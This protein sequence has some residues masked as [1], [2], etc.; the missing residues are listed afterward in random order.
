MKLKLTILSIFLFFSAQI[1]AE[2]DIYFSK[3]GMENGLSQPTVISIYQDELGSIWFATREGVNRYNGNNS[4]TAIKPI[5]NDTNSLSGSLVK[6]ICGN[7][8]EKIYIQTQN[9]VD[10]YDLETSKIS[11][12]ERKQINTIDYGNSNLWIA[13]NENLFYYQNGIKKLYVSLPKKNAEIKVIHQSK[14]GLIY[15]GTLSSG[16]Y[17]V[18]KDRSIRNILSST[19]Q[20]SDIFEDSKSN[21]WIATWENGLY[22]IDKNKQITQISKKSPNKLTLSTNFVRTICEDN[23][24]KIW[25][26]TDKGL[27][28]YTDSTTTLTHYGSHKFGNEQLSN[29]SIWALFKDKQGTIWVGTY[30]GGVNYFN[31]DANFYTYHNLQKG[32]LK[33][34]QFPIISTIIEAQ[35]NRLFLCTEGNGLILYNTKTKTYRNF[36]SQTNDLSKNNIKTAYYDSKNNELWLG[37]HLGGLNKLN[38][39]NF[40]FSRYNKIKPN[41]EQSDIV[42]TILPYKEKLLIAT[43]NGLFLFDKKTEKF[44]LFDKKLHKIVSYYNDI[45]IDKNNNLWIA[46]RGLYRYNILTGKWKK[47]SHKAE[48]P[49]SLSNKNVVKI[50]IDSKDRIWIASNGGGINLY[51]PKEDNFIHYNTT[52]S[53]LNNNY[54]SNIIESKSGHLLVTTTKG[55]SI[56]DTQQNKIHNYGAENGLALNSF[57]NGGMCVLKNGK[58]YLA[59]MNGMVS[60]FEDKIGI[61]NNDFKIRLVNLWINNTLVVPKDETDVLE[62]SLPYTK[63]IKLKHNQSSLTIEFASNNYISANQP[64]YRYKLEGLSNSWTTLPLGENKLNFINLPTGNYKLKLEAISQFNRSVIDS[65]ELEITKKPIFYRS[66]L[67]Y[68]LYI[69][70]IAFIIWRLMK[71]SRSQLL[72]KTSLEYE[73]K[74]KAHI[75]QVNQSKLKFFTNISHEFRT[76]L[77]LIGGQIDMILQMH[78]IPSNVYNK[79]LKIKRNTNNMKQLVDELL[80][81]RKSEQGFL[82]IQ[83]K[84]QDFYEFIQEIFH[85]FYDY[86][87]FKNIKFDLLCNCNKNKLLLWY[88]SIQMQ[89]VFYNLISNAFKYTNE[90]GSITI[91]VSENEENIEINITDTGIG[92]DSESMKNIFNRFY[93]VEHEAQSQNITPSTGIG[94]A[95]TKNILALHSATIKV[96]SE[97]GKGSIFTVTLKKGNKHFSEKQKVTT[98][99]SETPAVTQ[100]IMPDK[101]FIDEIIQ[102]YH[103][104]ENKNYSILIVEDN[105]EL[106][107]MQKRIFEPLYKVYTAKDGEE[108]LQKAIDLQPSI[109]LSDLMMPKMSGSE[110]CEKI[111]SNFAVCHIPVV[112]LTAQTAMEYNL[113]GL[114]LGA[115][116]YITKPFNV[117]ILIMRCNN[118]V[119]GRKMLQE[120]YSQQME[121]SPKMIATNQLDREFIEKAHSII[122]KHLDN[123]DFDINTFSNEMALG[124]T[125]L[126]S[127]IKGVTGHTPNDFIINYKMKKA[128]E[129]LINHLEYNISDISYMLGFSTPKYF[130]K[131]FKEHLGTSPSIFRKENKK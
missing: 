33:D 101:K 131:C 19:S 53:N 6:K 7:H 88:D 108:G 41:W 9:G 49:H 32:S 127:K 75:K 64:L 2:N 52:N 23:T 70:L 18:E 24:G 66:P 3:I 17:V 91:A 80:E 110:M 98:D 71:F 47:Y 27:Y 103:K 123:P 107:D 42:R 74:E 92:I 38:L 120:K 31:P 29:S 99:K 122:D 4:I 51:N 94:L 65:T 11:K 5:P 69:L 14:S 78:N 63:Q 56:L 61:P 67:A 113:E 116:D 102:T 84:E 48:D 12:I 126:F 90:N 109:I 59:G 125:S 60:F 130:A 82:N 15:L 85:S 1:I 89:K 35:K 20:I 121:I 81:F 115:D 114:R 21:L 39:N 46:S 37:L 34:K 111:K 54:I 13:E 25:I 16:V 124:R 30:F 87:K 117:K 128:T 26:G 96:D 55:F 83:V 22:K 50:F 44:S 105:E 8:S 100:S 118:L 68:L 86:S 10:E 58:I 40:T 62:K 106:R 45:K 76:P 36:L 93:Q 112:L 43:Y 95:L 28:K 72:L 129:L 77:T 57:Y 97:Q 104:N 79:I 119:N 73:K